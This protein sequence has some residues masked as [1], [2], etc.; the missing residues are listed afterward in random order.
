MNRRRLVLCLGLMALINCLP[1]PWAGA[2]AQEYPSKRITIVVPFA[3]GGIIDFMGRSVAAHLQQQWG[4]P[5]VVENKPG[6]NGSIGAFWVMQAVPDG[7]TLYAAADSLISTPLFV[8]GT[9]FNLERDLAPVAS[10]LHAPYVVITNPQVP[11]KDI[12]SLIDYAKANPGK[13][14]FAVT[15]ASSQLLDTLDFMAKAGVKMTIIPYKSGSDSLRAVLSNEAQAYFGAIFGLE[16]NIKAG[17]VVALAVT[18]GQP[19]AHLPNLPTVASAIGGNF[20]T[21][22]TYGFFS[23]RGTP[24]GTIEKLSKAIKDIASGSEFSKKMTAQGYELVALGPSE[25]AE[26]LSREAKRSTAVARAAGISPE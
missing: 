12:R 3:P 13:L 17:R 11:A 25:F 8:K 16:E 22:V 20:S 7:H 14:N 26:A 1:A 19:F 9:T 6:G 24:M 15:S 2:Q 4:Q 5:V 21:G 18:S 10:L 23:T